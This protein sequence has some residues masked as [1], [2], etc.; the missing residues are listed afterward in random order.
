MWK[1]PSVEFER[2]LQESPSLETLEKLHMPDIKYCSVYQT[3]RSEDIDCVKTDPVYMYMSCVQSV[4]QSILTTDL[5]LYHRRDY[6][7]LQITST[8]DAYYHIHHPELMLSLLGK[9]KHK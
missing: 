1:E 5:K 9:K 7:Y 6:L 3:T 8:S 2:F 4:C